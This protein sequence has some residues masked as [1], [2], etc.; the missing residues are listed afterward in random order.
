MATRRPASSRA[1]YNDSS[2]MPPPQQ[3]QRPKSVLAKPTTTR[4][5]TGEDL[6]RSGT[7][8]ATSRSTRAQDEGETHIQVI[9]RCRGRSEREMQESSP[10]IVQ[11]DGP[12]TKDLTIETATPV[13]SLGV[14][15]S[16]PSRTYPFDIVFGPEANQSMI[17]Y[18]VVGPML[19]E[20]LMGYNCTLFAYGQTGTGKTYT[21]QGDLSPTPM[22]NPAA[23]AGVIPRV[24]FKLFHE[25]EKS[26]TDFVVKISF[27]ELYNEELRDLLATDLQA[28]TALTQPMGMAA[29]DAKQAN[30]GGLKIF[31]EANKRGGVIIQGLEEIAVRDSKH[32]LALLT[33][34][35]ERR[36]IAATKFNDHSSR[37]HSIFTITVHLK[38]KTNMGDDLLKVGKLN[39]VDLAGSENIGRSGAENKRAREAGMI[40][41]SLL[42]LGRVINALVDKAQHVPYRESKLTRL[43]QDSLGGR[44]KTCIIAT[45]SPARS[46]LEETLSTLDYALRAK[47]IRNKPELNQRMTRNSLLKEYVAEIDRLK[48]DL[49]AAR[50]KNGIYF[51]EETWNE[52]NRDNELRKTELVEAKKQVM[53]I[54]NQLR[55]VRDEYDQSIALLKRKD[56]ELFGVRGELQV[57][58]E[59]LERKEG[60][61]KEAIERVQEEVVVRAAHQN[62][63]VVLNEVALGLK[64]AAAQGLKDISS[65]FEKLD[66]K[67]KIL[68]ANKKAV[69]DNHKVINS[70]SNALMQKLAELSQVSHA[71]RTCLKSDTEQMKGAEQKAH[72]D[73]LKQ[74]NDHFSTIQASIKEAAA[75]QGVEDVV[76]AKVTQEIQSSTQAFK[77]KMSTWSESL[78][79]SCLSLCTEATESGTKQVTLLEQSISLLYSLVESVCSEVQAYLQDERAFLAHSHG[80]SKTFVQEEMSHLKKQNE[81]LAKMVID[82]RKSAEKAKGELMRRIEGLLGEFLQERD[83][84]LRENAGD[85]Q[86]SNKEVE[87][88]LSKTWSQQDGGYA[89][90]TGKTE[91]MEGMIGEVLNEGVG[92][93][94]EGI[95]VAKKSKELVETAMSQMQ[96]T[97]TNSVTGYSKW[98]QSKSKDVGESTKRAL[99]EHSRAKRARIEASDSLRENVEGLYSS[100]QS[101]VASSSKRT[102]GFATKALSSIQEQ[103]SSAKEYED[104]AMDNLESIEQ[105]ANN[106]LSKGLKEDIPTGSTPKKRKWQYRD[107]WELTKSREELID[108][109]RH[110]RRPEREQEEEDVQMYDN[111]EKPK[112]AMEMENDPPIVETPPVQPLKKESLK[113]PME[114]SEP[115]IESR[116]RNVSTRASSRRPR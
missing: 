63:E 47:S 43:L 89:T 116:R 7:T 107:E 67:S 106:L 24:L 77:T 115:L 41:Q 9:I 22:G 2:A 60:E 13:S 56:E 85:L 64:N 49:L 66:R 87:G 94:D 75:H 102:D 45:V 103:N 36:Q 108:G 12:K 92:A 80:L 84:K 53:I 99:D 8:A 81:L 5:P 21:M 79:N 37:S 82:E 93:R 101:S 111:E 3:I 42:T 55:G 18:D 113:V 44:T 51:S 29:K 34:G 10:G 73:H 52:M 90:R 105:A 104:F 88:L 32:A 62:T 50:E 11:I 16:A 100:T 40:N 1:R 70:S 26:Y 23:N 54:E 74:I 28:P 38:E 39:L 71:L 46:N 30:D 35:S 57:A 96:T 20:V 25:L 65:L 31:D 27:V 61:L 17:Y 91:E 58:G 76:L 69:S 112:E 78:T 98:M 15:T 97:V 110:E 109:L 19:E 72:A 48:A 6:E 68:Q 4:T 14:I 86:R 95:K 83:V 59:E 33:K 114:R